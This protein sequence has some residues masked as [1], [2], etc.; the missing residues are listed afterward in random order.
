MNL[1]NF[2]LL[3]LLCLLQQNISDS[4][5]WSALYWI[6]LFSCNWQKVNH[7]LAEARGTF[8]GSVNLTGGWSGMYIILAYINIHKQHTAF[9]VFIYYINIKLFSL[10]CVISPK[11][12]GQS[13][14]SPFWECWPQLNPSLGISCSKSHPSPRAV[15]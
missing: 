5:Q 9:C 13:T 7:K 10:F 8:I 1:L 3:L 6:G 11:T 2:T 12:S 15:G 14:H 4:S